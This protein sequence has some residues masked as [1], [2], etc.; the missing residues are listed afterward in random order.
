MAAAPA[1]TMNTPT[2]DLKSILSS[3]TALIGP[4]M[5]KQQVL[6]LGQE[7][8]EAKIRLRNLFFNE[9][10][11]DS[12]EALASFL[13]L[14]CCS[15]LE[16]LE[17]KSA[18]S[19]FGRII[20]SSTTSSIP[21]KSAELTVEDI[22][23]RAPFT[24]TLKSLRLGYNADEPQGERDIGFL[25][26]VLHAMPQLEVLSLSQSLDDFSLFESVNSAQKSG[27]LP[28]LIS[29]S[30]AVN[31]EMCLLDEDEVKR[32]V[33]QHLSEKDESF[34]IDIELTERESS[35]YL[36]QSRDRH[37][38]AFIRRFGGELKQQ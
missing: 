16:S 1:T 12:Q 2:F 32:Q 24:K 31:T 25:N 10:Y 17:Y 5:T 11:K 4:A 7:L 36:N 19:S 21:L 22:H 27:F 34:H 33:L 23:I 30:V 20:L 37:F 28:N 18:G 15:E 35:Y 29:L 6:D 38:L 13:S 14:P 9:A 3:E 26:K 8:D